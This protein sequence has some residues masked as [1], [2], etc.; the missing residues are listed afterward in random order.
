M[1]KGRLKRTNF[2]LVTLI[3]GVAILIIDNYSLGIIQTQ[4]SIPWHET[5]EIIKVVIYSLLYLVVALYMLCLSIR[6]A[7]DIGIRKGGVKAI[8]VFYG[9]QIL[10]GLVLAPASILGYISFFTTLVISSLI[11]IISLPIGLYLLCANS[12]K[13]DNVY[14]V[15]E[16]KTKKSFIDDILNR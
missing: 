13:K 12:E 14:G 10:I 9:A 15:Y 2:F 8:T 1:W 3:L 11:N 16:E 5:L 7:Q 4:T 6:R